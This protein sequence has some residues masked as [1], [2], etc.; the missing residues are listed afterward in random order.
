[1]NNFFGI[2]VVDAVHPQDKIRA[3][4]ERVNH[5]TKTNPRPCLL[6]SDEFFEEML[7]CLPPIFFG[8]TEPSGCY[9]MM[10]VGEPANHNA[11]GKPVYET[12]MRMNQA[13]IDQTLSDSRMILNRWYFVGERTEFIPKHT[14][15]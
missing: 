15:K 7:E 6:V 5:E 4:R 14:S 10:Q 12:F 11:Q 1:M 9:S 2:P 8:T 3:D 13:A